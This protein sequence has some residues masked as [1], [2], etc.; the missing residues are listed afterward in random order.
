[1][2]SASSSSANVARRARGDEAAE[3]FA[4]RNAAAGAEEIEARRDLVTERAAE[5]GARDV[6]EHGEDG[7]RGKDARRRTMGEKAFGANIT[8]V[9]ADRYQR[10]GHAAR[11]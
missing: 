6:A 7:R 2:P 4:H 8:A 1:V 9:R 5:G 10:I 11:D 3:L